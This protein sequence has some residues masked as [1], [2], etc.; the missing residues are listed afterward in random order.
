MSTSIEEQTY[1]NEVDLLEKFPNSLPQWNTQMDYTA[2]NT[3]FAANLCNPEEYKA[4][5]ATNCACKKKM[6]HHVEIT[7]QMFLKHPLSDVLKNSTFKWIVLYLMTGE[8]VARLEIALADFGYTFEELV[9]K[10][11]QK[12]SS[13]DIAHEILARQK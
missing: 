3:N 5:I 6:P 8:V 11:A 13:S 4:W 2:A 7:L 1:R 9:S 10:R 12:V